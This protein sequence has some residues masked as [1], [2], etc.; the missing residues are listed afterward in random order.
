MPP[1]IGVVV[2]FI[3][4]WVNPPVIPEVFP[5][6]SPLRLNDIDCVVH[7]QLAPFD[8]TFVTYS[9]NLESSVQVNIQRFEGE[10]AKKLGENHRSITHPKKI[11]IKIKLV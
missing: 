9:R 1:T 2:M 5:K 8:Q 7:L 6:G 11:Y 10:V 4:G 3:N